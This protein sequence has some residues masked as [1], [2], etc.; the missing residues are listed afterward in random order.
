M[1]NTNTFKNEPLTL[2]T[3]YKRK[4]MLG[5]VQF[6][7]CN[8]KL[9]EHLKHVQYAQVSYVVHFLPFNT[10]IGECVLISSLPGKALRTLVDIARLAE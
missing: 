2:E 6:C 9:V 5:I 10:Y 7:C 3:I 4:K 8:G 1:E